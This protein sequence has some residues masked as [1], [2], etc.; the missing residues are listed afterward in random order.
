M[1]LAWFRKHRKK[2]LGFL[3]VFLMITWGMGSSIL[4]FATKRDAG[5]LFGRKVP[6]PEFMEMMTRWRAAIFRSQVDRGRAIDLTWRQMMYLHEAKRYGLGASRE[7]VAAY[8]L[9]TLRAPNI[10]DEQR[11]RA[12]L[13]MIGLTEQAYEQTIREAVMVRKLRELIASTVKISRDEAWQ[14]Y[15]NDN[16]KVK[17]CYLK[18]QPADFVG[19][20]EV[21]EKE[22]R[23]FYAKHRTRFRNEETGEPGYKEEEA[24]RVAYVMARYD[25]LAKTVKVTDKELLDYYNE[26]KEEFKLP[27]VEKQPPA[28]KKDDKSKAKKNAAAGKE[29]EKKEKPAGKGGK[30]GKKGTL[31]GGEKGQAGGDG[32]SAKTK[33][34]TSG[35]A[36]AKAKTSGKAEAA[37]TAKERAGAKPSTEGKTAVAGK[38]T[39]GKKAEVKYKPFKDV[40]EEIRKKLAMEKARSLVDELMDRADRA[41]QDA[42]DR[43]E[44][45][46][47]KKVAERVDKER[48]VYSVSEFVPVKDVGKLIKGCPDFAREVN[49]RDEKDP[50]STIMRCAE[51]KFI[52]RLVAR[53]PPRVLS[54]D[55]ARPKVE[56]DLKLDKA[57]RRCVTVANEIVKLAPNG[58]MSKVLEL[59]KE[60]VDK[61]RAEKLAVE[62]SK[63]FTRPK[64]FG[65]GGG[66]TLHA[67][68]TG[69]EGDHPNFAET[70]FSLEGDKVGVAIEEGKA[71]A[72]YLM[73]LAEKEAAKP[74]EF[75]AQEEQLLERYRYE[76]MGEVLALWQSEL[77]KQAGLKAL[78]F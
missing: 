61:S 16:T 46:D 20:V 7:E 76:K 29:G 65:F 57:F 50:P 62:E 68:D 66:D 49:E 58:P 43:S 2:L 13:R 55:E 31:K 22:L 74:E 77:E 45:V 42:L 19:L 48:L 71:A 53:R 47:L 15:A 26:H 9:Y 37:P 14:R 21:T 25:D 78:K 70:A 34:Q 35:K 23:D 8:A 72:C 28:P 5:I 52:F 56:E 3:A 39:A 1:N 59:A 63:L 30:S 73:Q 32:E 51:G 54:F 18:L 41:V 69:L 75:K 10:N 11:Y 40:K 36:K 17:V 33:T 24:V 27:P 12:Y 38:K 4:R 6:L 64:S 60:R 67:F 44:I